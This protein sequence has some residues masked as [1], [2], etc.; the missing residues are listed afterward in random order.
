M[1][2][3]KVLGTEKVLPAISEDKPA[4]VCKCGK[5]P[6]ML[7]YGGFGQYVCTLCG[8]WL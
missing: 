7:H 4:K 8:L 5:K 2:D 3:G 6:R 1:K